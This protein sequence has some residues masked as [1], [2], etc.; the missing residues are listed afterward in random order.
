MQKKALNISAKEINEVTG[1]KMC[2]HWF[3]SSQWK[4]P[5]EKQYQQL[6]KLFSSRN[7]ELLRPH[8]DL[9]NEYAT[10]QTK[11]QDLVREYDELKQEYNNL[12]R[13]FD[14]TS[15]V[16]YTDVW[17]YPP[18]QYY[19]GKHPCEKPAD[20]LEHVIKTS[21]IENGLVLDAFMGSGS[22]G[23]VS[24]KLNRK[25]IGVEMEKDTFEKTKSMLENIEI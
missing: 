5:N 20:L 19:P 13:P 22:T 25:F 9:T 15:E 4:L 1:T 8:N 11:Y 24:L 7:S 21:S 12:R 16:P 2:S 14:L 23:K 3:S 10:L 18:V 6:Q 17:T